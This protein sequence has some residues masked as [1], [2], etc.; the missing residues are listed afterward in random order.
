MTG[1]S[2]S[3][4]MR[5]CCSLCYSSWGTAAGTFHTVNKMSEYT[6]GDRVFQFAY[7]EK[8]ALIEIPAGCRAFSW[9]HLLEIRGKI[10]GCVRV[11]APR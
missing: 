4:G 8:G 7:L 10:V 11:R 6:F 9:Q 5:L 1:Q 2:C 3:C